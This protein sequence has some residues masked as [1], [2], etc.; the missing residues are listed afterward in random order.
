MKKPSKEILARAKEYQVVIN[1]ETLKLDEMDRGQLLTSLMNTIDV[2][3]RAHAEI[4]DVNVLLD[5]WQ[6]YGRVALL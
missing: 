6:Q 3:E 1:G 4:S 5:M 2:M